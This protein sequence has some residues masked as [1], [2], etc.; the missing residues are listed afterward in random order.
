MKRLKLIPVFILAIFAYLFPCMNAQNIY[1]GGLNIITT[2]EVFASRASRDDFK[3]LAENGFVLITDATGKYIRASK[4]EPSRGDIML[5][6]SVQT[7]IN[8]Y[9]GYATLEI[10]GKG[11]PVLPQGVYIINI[12]RE[13]DLTCSEFEYKGQIYQMAVRSDNVTIGTPSISIGY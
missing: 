5:A 10:T 7:S 1:D 2:C 4:I 6:R 9:G 11:S 12:Y 3:S 8:K 13:G